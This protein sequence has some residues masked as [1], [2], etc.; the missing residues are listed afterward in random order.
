MRAGA[1]SDPK[2]GPSPAQVEFDIGYGLA[3]HEG[4]GLLTTYGSLSMAGPDSCGVWPG[5][6]IELG[7]WI[8]L[9]VEG[10]RTT[11]AGGAAH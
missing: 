4:A 10:E 1:E 2:P 6:Q 11:Q 3:T 7:E 8:D 9:R 5:G